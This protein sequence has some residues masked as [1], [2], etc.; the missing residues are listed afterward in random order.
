MV[1]LP[2]INAPVMDKAS[3]GTLVA[4][5]ITSVLRTVVYPIQDGTHIDV[6]FYLEPD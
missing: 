2:L 1:I 5:L 6:L 3:K 4:I